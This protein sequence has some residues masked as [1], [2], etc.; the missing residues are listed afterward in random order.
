MKHARRIATG[1]IL[2]AIAFVLFRYARDVVDEAEP[3][4]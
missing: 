1:T 4:D 3:V 2:A